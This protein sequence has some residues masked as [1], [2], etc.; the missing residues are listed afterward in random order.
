[1]SLELII[2]PMFSGKTSELI[3]RVRQLRAIGRSVL[4]INHRYD[5]RYG[6]EG[7]ITH[8][9]DNIKAVR[10]MRL[11]NMLKNHYDY[12]HIAIDEAQFFPDLFA[13]VT[14]LVDEK[15]K[16]LIVAGL[17]GDFQRE[18][19]GDI[20]LLFPHA[21]EIDFYK[22][23]CSD[24]KNGIL[25]SFTKKI[26]CNDEKI[27]VGGVEKYVAVCRKCYLKT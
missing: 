7:A 19:F 9:G 21:N 2:G 23:Y 5:S 13:T 22:A 16:H 10:L 20:N 24:C 6:E 18:N 26:V 11:S 27:D 4:V 15:G 1:M 25:A 8:Y 3:K 14:S 17:S 12:D